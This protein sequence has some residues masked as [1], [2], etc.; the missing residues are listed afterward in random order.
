MVRNVGAI[1][2]TN[3]TVAKVKILKQ[4]RAMLLFLVGCTPSENEALKSILVSGFLVH[5][6]IWLDD[7]LSNR[8]GGVDLLLHLLSNISKLPVSKEMVTSSKLGKQVAAVEKH[9]ICVGG[10]N[11][12]AIKDRV[13]KV[14]EDWSASVKKLK[15]K[16]ISTSDKK[17]LKRS[18]EPETKTSPVL[19]KKTKTIN[20]SSTTKLSSLLQQV[21]G[22]ISYDSRGES[23][24]KNAEKTSTI[25]K[26]TNNENSIVKTESDSQYAKASVTVD[27]TKEVREISKKNSNRRIRWADHTGGPLSVSH[28]EQ[29]QETGE[30]I[31]SEET[32][33]RERKKRDRLKEKELIKQAKSFKLVDK[34]DSLDT[35]AM[36]FA[37]KWHQPLRLVPGV[38][39]QEAQVNSQEV[40]VQTKRIAS[41]MSVNYL[42][43]DDVPG[44]PYPLTEAEQ[45]RDRN[46]QSASVPQIIPFFFGQQVPTP[47]LAP[48]PPAP[49]PVPLP[50][51]LPPSIPP[52]LPIPAILPPAIGATLEVVRSM[53]LPDFLV[54]QN[55]QALQA[56]VASPGLLNTFVDVNGNY[57]QVK[58]M[59]LIQA[60][61][62][63]LQKSSGA[64]MSSIPPPPIPPPPIQPMFGQ[65]GPSQA[66]QYK[67][68]PQASTY[69]AP[70]K[71]SSN[72]YRGDQNN[73]DGNLHLSGYGPTTSIDSII[74]LFAPYVKVNEV[75][76]KSGFMFLNTS[77]SDGARRAREALNGVMIGGTPLRIN[78]ALRRNKN[79]A[80][81]SE[82][83]MTNS[84]SQ[85]SAHLPR[86]ALG[87]VDYD[88]VQD[89]RGNPATKNLFVAGYGP[90]TT[91]QQL[92]DLFS[93]HT[94]VTGIVV[95]GSFSFVNTL[96][97]TSAILARQA[98][99][100]ANLNGSTL[101]INFAK[102]SGRL[103]TSFD[104]GYDGAKKTHSNPSHYGHSY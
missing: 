23:T 101:R 50:T 63:Q 100:G 78:V 5:V 93:Q 60:M 22:S 29:F 67:P 99:V 69:K 96:E 56:L 77:D 41:V 66:S 58:I 21:K 7:I 90:G 43:E 73:T 47:A 51:S 9:K 1:T 2:S 68:L 103:G 42:S 39:H 65:Y 86:N 53:G 19:S 52:P 48:P 102:E 64:V 30:S 98:L 36:I 18:L 80:M 55:P 12:K 35:M 46:A 84:G 38:D 72:S 49:L 33:W 88:A 94:Q 76:P 11:E 95:K 31:P 79:P 34:D 45:T 8:V 25:K 87:Q 92:R 10:M 81:A 91:E 82:S 85:S 4:R 83:S 3:D 62:Q 61:N 28:L 17:N 13:S 6:K 104:S 70:S 27:D 14:K 57:D 20:T 40:A 15:K 97:K 71:P 37:S 74:S 89:D 26:I 44:N 32:S 24:N 59:S 16:S 54:G 75:V